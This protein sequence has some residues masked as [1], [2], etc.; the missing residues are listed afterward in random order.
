MAVET[1][2]GVEEIIPLKQGL[3]LKPIEWVENA[4][5]VLKRSFH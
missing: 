2:Y 1:A 4:G 5:Q 3:K